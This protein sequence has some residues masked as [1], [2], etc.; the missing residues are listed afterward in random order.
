MP[1]SGG[2]GINRLMQICRP[3]AIIRSVDESEGPT[4]MS[5]DT[6]VLSQLIGDIYDA[7]LDQ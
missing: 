7:A 1:R 5:A 3:A 4:M 6:E 2:G